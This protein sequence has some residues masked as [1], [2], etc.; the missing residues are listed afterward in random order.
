MEPR[1]GA[2]KHSTSPR[3]Q[4]AALHEVVALP[5]FANESGHVPKVVA[6]VRI[7]HDHVSPAGGLNTTAEGVT[8]STLLHP[9]DPG[10]ERFCDLHRA[11]PTA[12]VGNDHLAGQ[13]G[14]GEGS[15]G[16]LH[17]HTNGFM[18]IEARHDDRHLEVSITLPC[19][20]PRLVLAHRCAPVLSHP[21][22]PISTRGYCPGGE[23]AGR[24]PWIPPRY[25]PRRRMRQEPSPGE[26]APVRPLIPEEVSPPSFPLSSKP[27]EASRWPQH[28][29]LSFCASA[30][31][32]RRRAPWRPNR[33][34]KADSRP[35]FRRGFRILPGRD[36]ICT[37]T[38]GCSV[39]LRRSAPTLAL[40]Q[41]VHTAVRAATG[42]F[43]ANTRRSGLRSKDRSA[44]RERSGRDTG[45]T[46]PATALRTTT[47]PKPECMLV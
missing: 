34:R 10:A 22:T 26:P 2:G 43:E 30:N 37:L 36:D 41:S 16:L 19:S 7:A 14:L 23:E 42:T 9:H 15:D 8:I 32:G 47:P 27:N 21:C 44:R 24:R 18:L 46:A 11:I 6:V 3:R 28:R 25:C 31:S 38:L 1:H 39:P 5:Q 45:E 33:S 4:P 40:E 17:T 35:V 29:P 20:H 13:P 12:I